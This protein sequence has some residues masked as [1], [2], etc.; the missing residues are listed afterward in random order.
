MRLIVTRVLP[1]LLAVG[2]IVAVAFLAYPPSVVAS[3][4]AQLRDPAGNPAS[5]VAIQY[6]AFAVQ[7]AQLV[8]TTRYTNDC[9]VDLAGGRMRIHALGASGE[10]IEDGWSQIPALPAGAS[11]TD[12]TTFQK[13]L[14][15][16]ANLAHS[17][18]VVWTS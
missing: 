15:A 11:G 2:L 5:C 1:L 12:D 14:S 4:S 6:E 13:D 17:N 3:D 9:N 18:L 7:G 10:L 16:V 8:L